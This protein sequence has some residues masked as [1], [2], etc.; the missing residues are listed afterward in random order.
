MRF[1]FLRD[2]ERDSIPSLGEIGL[3]QFAPYLINRISARYNVNLQEALKPH[4]ITVAR[5][6]TLA[7]L[8]IS[9]GLTVNELAIYT[10]TEQSSMSRTLDAMEE[11]GLVRRQ[12]REDDMR[13]RAVTITDAGRDMFDRTWPIMYGVYCDIFKGVGDEEYQVFIA[14]LHK[15]LANV[16]VN[17]I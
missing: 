16:R 13:V 11:Q 1:G 17:E 5:I 15:I 14:T 12:P 10:V 6:R 4:D 7:V 9:P 2:A 8:T 3:S